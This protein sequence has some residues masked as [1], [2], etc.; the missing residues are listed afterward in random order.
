MR[1]QQSAAKYKSAAVYGSSA[2]YL[3]DLLCWGELIAAGREKEAVA[4]AGVMEEKSRNSLADQVF[5]P[6]EYLFAVFRLTDFERHT[7]RLALLPELDTRFGTFFAEQHQ[8]PGRWYLSPELAVRLYDR[9]EDAWLRYR[10]YWSADGSL[11][12][13]FFSGLEQEEDNPWTASWKLDRRIRNFVLEGQLENAGLAVF[14]SLWEPEPGVAGKEE[15][16]SLIRNMA[17]FMERRAGASP[18][19]VAFFLT[20]PAGVGKKRQITGFCRTLHQAVLFVHMR[21]ILAQGALSASLLAELGRES[22]IRQSV[23]CFDGLEVLLEQGSAGADLVIS[24]LAQALNLSNL[25]F[26]T[27]RG[28]WSLPGDG[29]SGCFVPVSLAVPDEARRQYLWQTLAA[30]YP[31]APQVRLGEIAAKFVLTPGQIKEALKQS[32][33]TALWQG[34]DKIEETCLYESCYRQIKHELAGS[35]ARKVPAVFTWEDLILP[36]ASKDLLRLACDQDLYKRV[37]YKE[38]GFGAKLPYGRGLSLLFSGPPGTGKTMGAQVVAGELGREL[39]KADLAGVVSKY[40]G[41]TEKNLRE[42]FRE[43]AKGQAVLFFDEADVLF[44]KRT[45][46]KE[47]NDKYSNMEAAFMLQEIEEYEGV[48]V[49]ATNL[50]QNFDE[51]FKRRIKFIIEFPFPNRQ[52]RQKLWRAAF[53]AAAPL[54]EDINWEYLACRFELSGSNI[55]NIAVNAAFVAAAR[56]KA[57]TMAEILLSLRNEL[58]KSGKMLSQEE[59]G[60]YYMYF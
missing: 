60:E 16:D 1:E 47:A 43:A 26:G 54:G 41:E 51:A 11:R 42:I 46:V 45:E 30:P 24:Y 32:E 36:P 53:P 25:V 12:R 9:K 3:R 8:A 52:Y 15:E 37:V 20:G 35:K 6:L 34:L 14:S 33:N 17:R 44:N 22:I 10:A 31:L 4:W 19:G 7:V 50:L 39:Y 49:L 57:V 18:K 55:K 2:A 28:E 56:G 58:A 21:K 48:C 40:I 29:F 5:L 59:F 13:F 23:L 27:A 38:W